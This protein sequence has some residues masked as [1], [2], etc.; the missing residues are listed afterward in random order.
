VARAARLAESAFEP[1][2]LS[3]LTVSG[4]GDPIEL[5]REIGRRLRDRTEVAAYS[6]LAEPYAAPDVATMLAI[7]VR[8][9]DALRADGDQHLLVIHD[10]F[11]GMLNLAPPAMLG[12]TNVIYSTHV[13]DWGVAS[14]EE[15]RSRAA[16]YEGTFAAAQERQG[17][18]FFVGS[19]S[20]IVGAAFGYEALAEYLD[21]WNRRGW[22][23]A[24][25]TYKRFDDP[26]DAE[27]F[28]AAYA[29]TGWGFV[30]TPAPGWQRPDPVRD[31][32]PTL[33]GKMAGYSSVGAGE[34][35]D[36]VEA[37]RDHAAP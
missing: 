9:H 29:A 18:P 27:L 6:L 31:D 28:G 19:F 10:G 23:W 16:L 26:L 13:F 20:T 14:L 1:T 5:W 4:I 7:Y 15:Y 32:L 35:A 12:L 11:K 22:S 24:L 30:R 25:W 21:L 37:V 17:A 8:L 3:P 34:N 2:F 36:M 33:V